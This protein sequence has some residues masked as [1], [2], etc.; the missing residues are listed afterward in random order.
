M[1]SILGFLIFFCFTIPFVFF[2]ALLRFFKAVKQVFE[3]CSSLWPHHPPCYST[4]AFLIYNSLIVSVQSLSFFPPFFCIRASCTSALYL[5][6]SPAY[7]SFHTS[8]LVLLLVLPAS[9]YSPPP[10]TFP[11]VS[12]SF[13]PFLHTLLPKFSSI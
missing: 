13:F 1:V 10:I 11:P 12:P 6:V 9:I 5:Q 3:H 4:D 8:P 2:L 7:W